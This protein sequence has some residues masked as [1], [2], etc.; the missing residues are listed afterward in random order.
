MSMTLSR[1]KMII[2]E[3]RPEILTRPRLISALHEVLDKQLALVVAPAGYGKTSLLVDFAYQ[4]DMPVCWLSLDALDRE[5]QRFLTYFVSAIAQHFPKFG[6]ESLSALNR[7]TSLAQGMKQFTIILTNDIYDHIDEHF[8]LAL[9]DY[10]FVDTVPEIR[11]FIG[12]FVQQVSEN[13]HVVLASRRLPVLTD[14]TLLVARD[15]VGGFDLE[16]LSFSADEVRTLFKKNYDV[17]LSDNELDELILQTE[18]WITGLHL[19]QK[20]FSRSVPDLGATARLT[21]IGLAEYFNQQV[22]APQ[23]AEIRTFLLQ[24]SFMDEFDAELCEAVLGVGDWHRLMD[25]VIRNN[26]FVQPIGKPTQWIRYH[27]LFQEFL[28][29]QLLKEDPIQVRQILAR[30][31][32]VSEERGE[33]EKAYQIYNQFGDQ[34]AVARLVERAG[35]YMVQQ[36]R[37]IALDGWLTSLPDQFVDGSPGLLSL[38]GLTATVKGE[39]RQGLELLERAEEG[40]RINQDQHGLAFALFRRAW[41]QR[42]LAN[43]SASIA[44]ADEVLQLCGNDETLDDARAEALRMKGFGLYRLGQSK[45]A[46]DY[47]EQSLSIFSKLENANNIALVQMELGIAHRSIGDIEVAK[48][49]YQKALGIWEESGDLFSQADILNNLGVLY[50]TDGE[51]EKAVQFFEQGLACTR[52]SGYV[53][54]E[55]LILTGLGD[56]YMELG[57]YEMGSH[58]YEH[59]ERIACKSDYRFLLNYL[60]LSSANVTR[61]KGDLKKARLILDTAIAWV[62]ESKSTYEQGLYR[63]ESGKLHLTSGDL[64]QAIDE[65]KIAIENFSLG[66]LVKETGWSRIWLAS[67]YCQQDDLGSARAEIIQLMNA[68]NLNQVIHPLSM[69]AHQSRDQLVKL[70]DDPQVGLA[71]TNLLNRAEKAQ[72]Y[73]PK[74]RWRLRRQSSTLPIP[75]ARIIIRSLGK[76]SVRVNGKL[77]TSSQ[78]KTH[79]VRELF[80]YI[81]TISQPVTKEEIGSMFWP[82]LTPQQL[83][84]RF[85]NDI[86]RLRRALGQ[87]IVLYDGQF[88]SFNKN[89][90][91]EYDLDIFKA[92]I[93]NA[94]TGKTTEEKISF[95]QA[96]VNVFHGSFLEDMGAPWI[97]IE[98]EHI[99]KEY[100]SALLALAK[101]YLDKGQQQK[102]IELCHKILSLDSCNEDAHRLAMQSHASLGNRP[103]VARQYQACKATLKSV[104]GI[105]P[106]PQTEELF[107]QLTQ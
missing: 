46:I 14:M 50:H 31:S 76:G 87:D 91:Y 59:A 66:S 83:K 33:W 32:E 45:Q 73:I 21:G 29:D 55:A 44:D 37:F 43:Y 61:L 24:T 93:E 86:Y 27:H 20:G 8:A 25:T 78:W 100:L 11:E 26:L 39:V 1:T 95:Y 57:D 97:M 63:L 17:T 107:K 4:S 68:E 42:L 62:D 6:S 102:A 69:T 85:K 99:N 56:L 3:R 98:R 13:C 101:L 94:H 79:S 60:A 22:L 48:G 106:S 81:L 105:S 23:P 2:P 67:A 72:A 84:T 18:G 75:S 104:L 88:Y 9:D 77:V 35:T 15:Q 64:Q 53:R 52:R 96:A 38:K 71:L 51:Y 65:L 103:A 47:L 92:S 10:H 41:I 90:D 19:S 54:L 70:L 16:K 82:E 49:L 7:L 80:Y 36:G 12:S 40:Y 5:P 74:L 28:Q 30:L 58:A 34:A 89:L